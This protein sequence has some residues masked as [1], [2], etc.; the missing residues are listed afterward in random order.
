MKLISLIVKNIKTLIPY[1]SLIALYF[2]FINLE[3]LEEQKTKSIIKS[4]SQ[5]N[6]KESILEDKKQVR[7]SIPVFPYRE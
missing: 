3:A 5:I 6:E 7:I 2:F 4:E 1:F